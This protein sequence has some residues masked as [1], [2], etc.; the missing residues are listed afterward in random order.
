[1]LSPAD[2]VASPPMDAYPDDFDVAVTVDRYQ[3]VITDEVTRVMHSWAGLRTFSPDRRPVVGFDPRASGFYWLGGQGG[4]GVQ[5]S[6]GLGAMVAENICGS[7][8][9]REDIDVGRY[10]S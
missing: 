2:E 10:L 9:L 6:P 4:F 7:G 5:T 3:S 8:S 1:M